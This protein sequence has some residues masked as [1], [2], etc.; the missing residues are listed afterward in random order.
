MN[1]GTIATYA[2]IRS[3]RTRAIKMRANARLQTL[4]DDINSASEQNFLLFFMRMTITLFIDYSCKHRSYRMSANTSL[5]QL[6]NI[7][8]V[9]AETSFRKAQCIFALL[10]T[11]KILFLNIKKN[12]KVHPLPSA[13][14]YPY[15]GPVINWLSLP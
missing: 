11:T 10:C 15:F 3:L 12:L 2:K 6:C 7:S 5:P 13:S 1:K 4:F 9:S 8:S 14:I